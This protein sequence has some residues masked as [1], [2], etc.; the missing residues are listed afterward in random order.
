MRKARWYSAQCIF[1]HSDKG[2]G[3]KQM[4]EERVILV[5]AANKDHAIERAETEAKQYS[6]ELEGCGYVGLT[7]VFDLFDERPGDGVEVFSRMRRSDLAPNEYL[8]QHYPAQP[9]DCEAH[10]ETHRWHN[11][12]NKHSACYHC[13]VIRAG[14]LWET[15]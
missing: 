11:V 4:Y 9:D 12:D 10:G 8:D 14:R 2:H 13:R 7:D 3:P 15:S 5:R 6:N 1:L